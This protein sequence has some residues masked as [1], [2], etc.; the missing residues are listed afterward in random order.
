MTNT[1][2][3]DDLIIQARSLGAI[4]TITYDAN[5]LATEGRQVHRS[6]QVSNYPGVGPCPMSPIS[7]AE[8][9]REAN[10]LNTCMVYVV[11]EDGE[12]CVGNAR[13]GDNDIQ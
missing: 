7:A 5:A 2:E 10:Y 9:L 8:A 1:Q 11:I 6:I 4:V 13:G 12:N 3:L